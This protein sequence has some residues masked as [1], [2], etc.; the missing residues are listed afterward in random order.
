MVN[1]MLEI[2]SAVFIEER[3]NE[4]YK[5]Y[6]IKE[7]PEE[8]INKI[9]NTVGRYI[10]NFKRHKATLEEYLEFSNIKEKYV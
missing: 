2:D 10:Y 5:I 9:M 3:K 4:S 7:N 6:C 1:K 8:I